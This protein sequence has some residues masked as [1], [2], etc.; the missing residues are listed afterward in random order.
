MTLA[1]DG[2]PLKKYEVFKNLPKSQLCLAASADMDLLFV[3]EE[4]EAKLFWETNDYG[5]S[6]S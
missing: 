2:G 4:R 5:L 1:G 6:L 3:L